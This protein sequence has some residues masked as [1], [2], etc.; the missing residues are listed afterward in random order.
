[1]GT[2]TVRDFKDVFE[3]KFPR[4]FARDSY[5][6]DVYTKLQKF[7]EKLNDIGGRNI[8]EMPPEDHPDIDATVVLSR[9]EWDELMAE[10]EQLDR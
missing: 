1:M 10:M 8:K 5:S 3:A 9:E 6:G 4:P 7:W 2:T